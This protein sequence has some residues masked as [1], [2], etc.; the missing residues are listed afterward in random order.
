M[1]ETFLG[2]G[3]MMWPLA[4]IAAGVL[5]M[6]GRA[7][8]L[9]RDGETAGREAETLVQAILFWGA[10]GLVLGL[11]GTVVGLI[12]ISQVLARFAGVGA[13]TIWE[14]VGLSLLPLVFG[15]MIA[16]VAALLW[17]SLGLRG[18]AMGA[19]GYPRVSG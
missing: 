13:P 18:R 2:G 17:F 15:I 5:V 7:L 10:M 1:I 3:V 12:Q 19:F 11:L 4:A 14:G 6:G 8:W 9:L 16:A